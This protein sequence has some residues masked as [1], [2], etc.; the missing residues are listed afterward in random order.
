MGKVSCCV[1]VAVVGSGKPERVAS[2][3]E[4]GVEWFSA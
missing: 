3:L 4:E 2:H 1:H